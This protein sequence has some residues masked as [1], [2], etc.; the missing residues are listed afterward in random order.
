MNFTTNIGI[1]IALIPIFAILIISGVGIHVSDEFTQ[2][3]MWHSWAVT[4]VI[5]A[6]FFLV[7][8]IYHVKGHW[9]WFKSLTKTLK[10]KASLP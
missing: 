5:A 7:L 8:G 3:E 10:K 1:D 9:V 2:H 6:I 4:H